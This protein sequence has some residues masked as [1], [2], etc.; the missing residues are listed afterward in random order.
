MRAVHDAACS[1][2]QFDSMIVMCERPS[3]ARNVSCPLCTEDE[4]EQ[5]NSGEVRIQRKPKLIPTSK[6]KHHLGSHLERLALFAIPPSHRILDNDDVSVKV[7]N[8]NSERTDSRKWDSEFNRSTEDEEKVSLTHSPTQEHQESDLKDSHM[9]KTS[10]ADD[11]VIPPENSANPGKGP[12]SSGEDLFM[13]TRR[14]VLYI[15]RV[16]TAKTLLEVM[17][18]P[19]TLGDEKKWA[20]IVRDEL[21][22]QDEGLTLRN[23][24]QNSS[25]LVDIAS[26]S[27]A[28]L[29]LI[30]LENIL[31][32]E[33]TGRI[34]RYND[35]RD[36]IA[37]T[38]LQHDVSLEIRPSYEY[39]ENLLF[40]ALPKIDPPQLDVPPN[41]VEKARQLIDA[42]DAVLSSDELDRQVTWAEEVL[43]MLTTSDIN[44]A[45]T[46]G[47]TEF[48]S[49]ELPQLELKLL[50]E[51]VDVVEA[52]I[53]QKHPQAL[54]LMGVL[55]EFGNFEYEKDVKIAI[56]YYEEAA[57]NGF[58]R[59]EYRIGYHLEQ[60]GNLATALHHYHRGEQA[61]DSGAIYRLAMFALLGQSG[62]EHNPED[63]IDRLLLSA[64][65]ADKNAPQSLYTL[66]MLHAHELPEVEV[67]ESLLPKDANLA[68][69]YL[70][71][72]AYYGFP[73]AQLKMGSLY[74][75][76]ELNC[77][78]NPSLSIHY[79][80]LAA[81]RG[82]A[83]A[84]MGVC[85]WFLCGYEG[86]FNR[87][88]ELAYEF[89]RR[90]AQSDN[91]V[92]E[93]AL[94]YFYEIGLWVL[95]DVEMAKSWYR[96]AVEHGN[97]DAL[98]RLATLAEEETTRAVAI[99]SNSVADKDINNESSL[100]EDSPSGIGPSSPPQFDL[101]KQDPWRPT[102]PMVKN[103]KSIAYEESD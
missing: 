65:K 80:A 58:A 62:H 73:K 1:D 30:T 90:A 27:Y 3:R 40:S 6:L 25:S 31:N 23:P 46:I 28:K 11:H 42:R 79:Y 47:E 5:L 84:E 97:T 26:L 77:D 95:K 41:S 7:E 36:L 76:C 19:V 93:F 38:V 101:K 68:V 89:A 52:G 91:P 2:L 86:E 18:K 56:Q 50:A 83:D 53:Q 43:D 51:A 35:Y 102:N 74:E 37:S 29:K 87:N 9:P 44:R 54:F 72:A 13:E 32:L 49:S 57:K 34:S 96:I 24:G 59:A 92:A 60:S 100:L 55:H 61:G 16:Q 94:G 75:H 99:D 4:E 33:K 82:E 67:S 39:Y 103:L 78:F 81:R 20:Q 15:T 98:E 66:G 22:Q 70:K 71:K 88:D 21:K 85:K 14:R 17:A 8:H 10:L 12:G 63:G 64:S 48:K 45:R 69:L